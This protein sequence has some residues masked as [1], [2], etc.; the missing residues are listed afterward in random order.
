MRVGVAAVFLLVFGIGGWS[1][2]TTVS[3]AVVASGRVKVENNQQVVQHPDGGVVRQLDVKEGQHVEAGDILIGLDDR[4]QRAELAILEGQLYE[5]MA[6]IGRLEAEQEDAAAPDFDPELV[7][8]AAERPDIASL[9]AGQT[10]LFAARLE[11]LNREREQLRERQVQIRDEIKGAESQMNALEIQLGFIGEELRDQRSLLDRG[12]T[13]AT[14]VLSL[15][16]EKARLDGEFGA[17]TAQ[18]AQARGRITEIEIQIVGREATRREEAISELRDLRSREAELKQQRL[19]LLETLERLAIRAP[20]SGSV[21]G[22][23]VFTERAVIRPAEPILYIVPEAAEL[24]V[25]AR[26]EPQQIDQVFVDQP[27]RLRF[28]AFN[29]RTTPEVDAVVARLSADAIVDQNTGQSYYV[30]EV[31]ITP[32]GRDQLGEL[33]LVAGMPVEAFLRTGDRTPLSFILK[34]VTDY[35][36]GALTER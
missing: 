6:R 23:T 2:L 29:Q 12:L 13:Q 7:S 1:A 20:R 9:V 27:A 36:S 3:G 18:I 19:S 31:D 16:R 35:F 28:S 21:I 11:T 14:R 5:I 17:L 22:L 34:P 4:L 15:E 26:I 10:R 8:V 24:V 25:E 30:A 33:R 32:L